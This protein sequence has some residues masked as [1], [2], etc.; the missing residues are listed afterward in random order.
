MKILIGLKSTR[1]SFDLFNV[2]NYTLMIIIGAITLYPFLN[3]LA[4]SLNDSVDTVRGGIT[5]FPRV[6]S[7]DSYREI[8]GYDGL[9]NGFAVS[10]IRTVAG[11][12]TGLL[13]TS[14][15]AYTLSRE[16]YFARRFV[17]GIFIITMYVGGGLIPDYMLVRSLGLFNNFFVYILPGLI[18]VFNVIVIRSYIDGLPFELQESAKLDGANDIVIYFRIV[19]PLCTPVLSVMALFIAVGHWNSWFDTY[20]YCNGKPKLTTLQFEL[21]KV[22][23][24]TQILAGSGQNPFRQMD[25]TKHIAVSPKSIQ[26]A[27]TIVATLPILLVYPFVQNYFVKGMTVGAV[28]S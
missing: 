14:M 18:G 16:D 27:M 1:K 7:L 13:C 2:F 24:Q 19:M 25:P 4:V 9:V 12:A 3:V 20:L 21:Q 23:Q 28:K 8:L 17:G 22:L 10:A 15:L 26:M 5:I 11:T 6:F